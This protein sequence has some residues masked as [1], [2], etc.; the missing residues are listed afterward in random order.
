MAS[1]MVLVAVGTDF[2]HQ[3]KLNSNDLIPVYMNFSRFVMFSLFI[4]AT[5][6]IPPLPSTSSICPH[7]TSSNKTPTHHFL[8]PNQHKYSLKL[9]VFHFWNF[10]YFLFSIYLFI[11]FWFAYFFFSSETL[12][13]IGLGLCHP[14]PGG[15]QMGHSGWRETFTSL[16]SHLC[17]WKGRGTVH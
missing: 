5:K 4:W 6:L 16:G 15:R 17:F 2:D 13:M 11:V 8:C 3:Q 14:V 1:R 7:P 10:F 9:K 12:G